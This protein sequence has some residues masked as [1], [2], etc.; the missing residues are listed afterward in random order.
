MKRKYFFLVGALVLVL[1][2]AAFVAGRTFAS[3]GCFSDT[4]GHWAEIFICWLK[5]N[6]ISSGYADG[7]YHPESNITRAEMAK[8]LY[9]QAN[10]P[11]RI[12]LIL[13]TAG[14]G[15]W[16]PL[17]SVDPVVFGYWAEGT[18]IYRSAVGYEVLSLQADIP[19]MLYGKRLMLY[20]VEFCYD[21]DATAT[22]DYVQINSFTHTAGPGVRVEEF[23][24]T[25]DRTD[26]ACR[27][28]YVASPVTLTEEMGV[29]FFI[30]VNWTNTATP[31]IIGRTTFILWPTDTEGYWPSAPE[32]SSELKMP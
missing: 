30:G 25:T 3:T 18:Q 29:N 21:A 13:I 8:M 9:N 20:G 28:Y 7:T 15:D 16:V 2:A 14:Y 12:G 27:A 32:L 19:T 1:L 23:L 17:W 10:Q 11:P 31:F 5:D 6:S 22:L 4:N 24:D 26:A